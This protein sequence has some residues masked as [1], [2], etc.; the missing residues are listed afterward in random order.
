MTEVGR[1]TS[2]FY[3]MFQLTETGF[4]FILEKRS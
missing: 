1:E 4:E 2:S 3:R